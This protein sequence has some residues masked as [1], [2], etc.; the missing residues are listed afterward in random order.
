MAL[1]LTLSAGTSSLSAVNAASVSQARRAADQAEAHARDLREQADDAQ[2]QAKNTREK[3]NSLATEASRSTTPAPT[4]TSSSNNTGISTLLQNTLVGRS[5]ALSRP[6]L[7]I[8]TQGQVTGRLL[9][10]TA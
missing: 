8:N 5:A 10:V 9:N 1:A 2:T 3:A 7:V 4:S 6:A